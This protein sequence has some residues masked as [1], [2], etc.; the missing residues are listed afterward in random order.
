MSP[1]KDRSIWGW[2]VPIVFF[3]LLIGCI[4]AFYD[5]IRQYSAR[6][7]FSRQISHEIVQTDSES[8][9][10]R[11]FFLGAGGGAVLGFLTALRSR[12]KDSHDD[13]A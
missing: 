1:K 12:G 3:A 9:V 11:R 6:W 8:T 7:S 4:F 2:I 5:Y 13:D 10:I